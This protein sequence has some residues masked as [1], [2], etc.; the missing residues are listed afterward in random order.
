MKEAAIPDTVSDIDWKTWEPTERAV[1]SFMRDGERLLLIRKKK[2]L[3]AGKINAPGGRIDPGETAVQA[4][5]RESIEEVHMEPENPQKRGE[6]FFQF[7]DGYKLH[8]E[9]FFSDTYTGVPTETDE[10][11]PF[12]CSVD[13]LPYHDMWEDDRYW[14]PLALEGT[15]FKA[16]FI[17]DDD[18]MLDR[19]IDIL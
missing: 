8:G 5:I 4:A 17:F 3:G 7:K 13:E 2:G 10:A 9:V 14:L 12:W 18:R 1:L 6:L 15:P 16:Y 19:K 11:D